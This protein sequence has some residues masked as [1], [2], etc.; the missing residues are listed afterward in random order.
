MK[1]RFT[2]WG[3]GV[4]CPCW[5]ALLVG[6]FLLTPQVL[7]AQSGNPEQ[8]DDRSDSPVLQQHAR[9][10]ERRLGKGEVEDAPRAHMEWQRRARGIPSTEFQQ[11]LL[12]LRESR[13]TDTAGPAVTASTTSGSEWVAIGRTGADY[14]QNGFSGLVRDSRRARTVL[15]HPTDANTLYF[16]T[17]GGR[18]WVTH[19]FT[20]NSTGRIMT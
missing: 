9:A 13:S 12:G 3:C 17:S 10:P 4:L 6:A 19:N 18:L 11:H 2:R 5:F 20:A 8:P 1:R 14:E 16:L 7:H 15:P